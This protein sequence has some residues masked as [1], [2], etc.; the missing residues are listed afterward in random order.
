VP[1]GGWGHDPRDPADGRKTAR[2]AAGGSR[3]S[4]CFGVGRRCSAAEA[5]ATKEL[6]AIRSRLY[7]VIGLVA[8]LG[9]TLVFPASPTE[10]Q[11]AVVL[12]TL[13]DGTACRGPI[14]GTT[15]NIVDQRAN[16]ACTDGRWILGEPFDLGDG[17]QVAVLGRTILQGQRVSDDS[18]PC[19][20]TMCIVGLGL[21]EVAT[22]ATLPRTVYIY[23][24]NGG[25]PNTCTFQDGTTF[26]LGTTRANYLCDPSYWNKL[27]GARQDIE[28]WIVGGPMSLD[29][30][31]GYPTA[32]LAT[33]VRQNAPLMNAPSPVCDKPFCV[34]YINQESLSR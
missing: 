27:E 34:L 16:Y 26:Y 30:S 31:A 9:L 6:L 33:V 20:D 1:N 12:L 4:W 17:R 8:L 11:S 18:D 28:Y 5:R 2:G 24:A 3:H 29:S 21:A 22:S 19:Q 7:R 15:F 13:I 32:I 10:A 23:R 14:T 25:G